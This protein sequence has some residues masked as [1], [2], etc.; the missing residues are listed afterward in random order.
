MSFR[1]SNT[2]SSLLNS[3]TGITMPINMLS[4]ECHFN[5]KTNSI[6]FKHSG[7]SLELFILNKSDTQEVI[8][9]ICTYYYLYRDQD[10]IEQMKQTL[11]T[12]TYSTT[13]PILTTTTTTTSSSLNSKNR[14]DDT[15][16]IDN[17][18]PENDTTVSKIENLDVMEQKRIKIEEE[19]ITFVAKIVPSDILK[20]FEKQE[21]IT[22]ISEL[23]EK[24]NKEELAETILNKPWTKFVLFMS[25]DKDIQ[26][27]HIK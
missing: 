15:G 2:S 1:I 26:V 27:K 11:P 16:F 21:I 17:N 8:C 19:R 23:I 7:N 25:L 24:G 22:K 12:T 14:S 20:Y 10:L 4:S 18:K 6:T 13:Q 3:K 9:K 5:S